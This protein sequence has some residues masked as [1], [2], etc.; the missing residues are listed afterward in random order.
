M[1]KSTGKKVLCSVA[2]MVKDVQWNLIDK[3]FAPLG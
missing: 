2:F 1:R 3:V